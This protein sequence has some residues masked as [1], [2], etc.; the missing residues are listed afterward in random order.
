MK[1]RSTDSDQT[2]DSIADLATALA[3]MRTPEQVRAIHAELTAGG[4]QIPGPNENH[5]RLTFYFNTPFGV[6]VE[7]ESFLG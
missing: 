7:V 1:R 6:I 2:E 3:A 4:Y 5:G